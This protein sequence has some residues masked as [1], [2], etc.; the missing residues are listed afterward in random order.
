MGYWSAAHT[1]V[2]WSHDPVQ[3]SP[4]TEHFAPMIA[5]VVVPV[6]HRSGLPPQVPSQHS[7]LVAQVSPVPMQGA[8]QTGRPASFAV[9]EPWQQVSPAPHGAPRGRQAPAT[10]S[11]RDVVGSQAPQHG[12]RIVPAH[13]SPAA[14]HGAAARVQT[15]KGVA[16]SP[17]QQ[18][19]STVHGSPAIAQRVGP[20]RPALQPSEQQSEA[21]VHGAP[22]VRQ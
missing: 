15:P 5:Q 3:Q 21:A 14:R 11:Q 2:P 22:F 17:E 10:N 18:S 9:Q 7:S 6:S 19:P 4:L 13:V 8:V 16:Q 20:Q 12:G 1:H